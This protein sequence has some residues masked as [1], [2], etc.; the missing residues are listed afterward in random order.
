MIGAL[1]IAHPDWLITQK[2]F[3]SEQIFLLALGTYFAI[4]GNN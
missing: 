2:L 1:I 3:M 4:R